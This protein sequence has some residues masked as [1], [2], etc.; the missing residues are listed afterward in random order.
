[1]NDCMKTDLFLRYYPKTIAA[2]CVVR[3]CQRSD[4]EYELPVIDGF[5]WYEV[6]GVSSRDVSH[7]I[8]VLD[9][10]YERKEAPDWDK[11]MATVAEARKKKFGLEKIDKVTEEEAKRA[12]NEEEDEKKSNGNNKTYS[13]KLNSPRA[14]AKDLKKKDKDNYK[15]DKE[16]ERDRDRDKKHDRSRG[17]S[18]D[19]SRDKYDRNRRNGKRSHSRDRDRRDDK[20]K[21]SFF[22]NQKYLNIVWYF[23]RNIVKKVVIIVIDHEVVHLVHHHQKNNGYS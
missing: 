3:T 6:Y 11:L 16:R 20:D 18:R 9:K 21:V 5:H 8:E 1:M 7:I 14:D 19:Y 17:R 15:R 10:L 23:R 4:P 12:I 13:K 22:I 2:A